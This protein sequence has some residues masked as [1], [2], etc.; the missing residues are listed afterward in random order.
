[1][2]MGKN[3]SDAL[4]SG[5][6]PKQSPWGHEE[7]QNKRDIY[8][9]AS[10]SPFLPPLLAGLTGLLSNANPYLKLA[11]LT[12]PLLGHVFGSSG[13]NPR[14]ELETEIIKAR[15]ERLTD[16][17][18]QA[19]GKFT[20]AERQDIR[21]AN[22]H[23]L[24][25]VASNIAQRGLE[26]SGVAG[27]ILAEAERAP[28]L[29]A[30][31]QAQAKLTDAELKAFELTQKM[32][33]EDDGFAKDLKKLTDYLAETEKGEKYDLVLKNLDSAITSFQKILAELNQLR[34]G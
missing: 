7:V 4:S 12:L 34:G 18:R 21:R 1:M 31:K 24:N 27:Q 10:E 14:Q 33:K 9:G 8:G 20:P 19:K 15:K 17:R 11:S 2:A 13:G 32:V 3:G 30:Q 23:I 26:V 5:D 6:S 16:L 28:F 29:E 25:R 22:E